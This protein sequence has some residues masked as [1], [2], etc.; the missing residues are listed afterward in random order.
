MLKVFTSTIHVLCLVGI[1]HLWFVDRRVT[2][3]A[4]IIIG[5]WLGGCVVLSFAGKLM[6][7]AD[8]S[9]MARTMLDYML[10]PLGLAFLIPSLMLY[11]KQLPVV[12]TVTGSGVTKK[13]PLAGN[14]VEVTD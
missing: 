14:E 2:R 9:F 13:K 8:L 1:T 10:Q 11:K 7:D 6:H 4:I 5:T 12:A 3:M